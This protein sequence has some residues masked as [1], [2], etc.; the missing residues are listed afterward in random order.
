[1]T[2][3]QQQ[4]RKI[5]GPVVITANRLWDGAVVY[6]TADNTWTNDLDDAAIV[7]SSDEADRLLASALA[8]EHQVVGAYAA[9]MTEESGALTPAN[10]RERIRRNGP[11]IFAGRPASS[12]HDPLSLRHADRTSAVPGRKLL[13]GSPHVHL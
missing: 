7:T 1:M 8:D 11:T 13:Q 3:P 10:L 9:P 2:A 12:R 4:R 6:R 5:K